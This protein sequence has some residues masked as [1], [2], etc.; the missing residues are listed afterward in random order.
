MKKIKRL[1]SPKIVYIIF[2]AV[3]ILEIIIASLSAGFATSS[4][5]RDA[6]ISNIFLGFLG[7]IL[8]SLPWLIESRFKVDIPNYLEIIVL[9]FL[10]G[11]IILG[12][13]HGFLE[14]V[15]GY[16]KFLHTL[17]GIIIS[18]I[19]YEIIHSYNLSKNDAVK[20]SPGLLSIFAFCFSITLLV[21]WE[22]YE[23]SVD[24]IAY[25]I[26]NETSRNMQ[27]Y[28]WVNDSLVYPQPY[29]LMDTMLDLI[30]GSIGAA[31]V[32]FIGWRIL[33]K[34]QTLNL[35]KELVE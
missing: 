1:D 8:F 31:L 27:R 13:I 21:V 30:V 14:S 19:A 18:V 20:L 10:F 16:D 32:S 24:T 3:L 9:S 17:S 5:Q 25:N 11:A 4:E 29:G 35:R 33:L 23:F 15:K 12:N 22:F 34:K 2:L 28:Q 7:I 6:A 26:N